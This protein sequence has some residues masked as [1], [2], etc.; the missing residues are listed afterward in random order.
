ML[1]ADTPW[2]PSLATF[3]LQDMEEEELNQEAA[4]SSVLAT[5]EKAQMVAASMFSESVWLMRVVSATLSEEFYDEA[6][7][8]SM[9][10]TLDQSL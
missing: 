6:L 5:Y 3:Q 9:T 10:A 7:G 8:V 2:D 4:R 1:V